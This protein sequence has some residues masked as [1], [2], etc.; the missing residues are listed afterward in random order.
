MKDMG[1]CGPEEGLGDSAKGTLVGYVN[2]AGTRH[3]FSSLQIRP[4]E[5]CKACV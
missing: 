1:G 5:T 4:K 2:Q 3:I